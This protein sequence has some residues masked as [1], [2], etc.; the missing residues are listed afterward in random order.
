MATT[1]ATFGQLQNSIP[2]RKAFRRCSDRHWC[3]INKI[4][5]PCLK[6]LREIGYNP[7][8]LFDINVEK[9]DV[10]VYEELA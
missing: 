10:M 3:F 7:K 2:L 8:R 5:Y 1:I 6:K 4:N 9:N